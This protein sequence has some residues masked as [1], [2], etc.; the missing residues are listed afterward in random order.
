MKVLNMLT[1]EDMKRI[2]SQTDLP[3]LI[4]YYKKEIWKW[5]QKES[6]WLSDKNLLEGCRKTVDEVASKLVEISKDNANLKKR[7]QE[8]EG[9]NTIIKGIGNTSPEM[10]KL[11]ARVKELNNS[12]SI[13]LEINDKFQRENKKL[14]DD[15]GEKK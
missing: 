2:H 15:L 5:K 14:Q 6:Q 7:A 11:Q 9:E 12:L 10:K 8:A 1:S 4:E 13:A 3:L